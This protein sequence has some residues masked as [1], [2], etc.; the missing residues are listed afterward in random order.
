MVLRVTSFGPELMEV[1]RQASQKAVEI[2]LESPKACRRLRFRF[3]ELRKAMR[4]EHHHLEKIADK[5][6][7]H[8]QIDP[9]VLTG[10]PADQDFIK[11]IRKAGISIKEEQFEEAE[12]HEAKQPAP[13]GEDE[14]SGFEKLIADG[15]LE[16]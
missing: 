15:L 13:T 7:F 8:I 2:P 9:P 1:F 6:S 16:K 14:P 12:L 4:R 10:K 3:Y 5:V 11:A